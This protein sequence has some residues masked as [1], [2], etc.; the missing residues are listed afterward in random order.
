M[1][2]RGN[3]EEAVA[4]FQRATRL[5]PDRASAH[6]NLAVAYAQSGHRREARD[7]ARRALALDPSYQRAKHLLAALG[8]P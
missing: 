7:E 1:T 3:L 5:S 2:A 4:A 6:L 8:Q